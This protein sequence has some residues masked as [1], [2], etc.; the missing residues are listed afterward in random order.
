MPLSGKG[1]KIMRSMKEQ[2]GADKGKSGR[3]V[4]GQFKKW[5]SLRDYLQLQLENAG[6]DFMHNLR[7]PWPFGAKSPESLRE[8]LANTR[9]YISGDP[10]LTN[11]PPSL[12]ASAG[13]YAPAGVAG[14]LALGLVAQLRRQKREEAKTA[15]VE[16]SSGWHGV[17]KGE[18]VFYASKNKGTIKGVEK[19]AYLKG[20]LAK[21]AELM[22]YAQA[23]PSAMQAQSRPPG[24]GWK[25]TASGGWVNMPTAQPKPQAVIHE[26]PTS[27]PAYRLGADNE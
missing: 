22:K 26:L 21:T 1:K 25:Q 8:G 19:K 14:A 2:Y 12:G 7:R 18:S 23:S 3:A 4:A 17:D 11:L 5:A 9:K 20:F 16:E 24:P 15:Q 10:T 6:T 13:Y 27:D